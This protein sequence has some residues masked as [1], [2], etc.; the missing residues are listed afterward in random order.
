M[1]LAAEV[2]VV[3]VAAAV[4]AAWVAIPQPTTCP[5]WLIGILTNR[6]LAVTVVVAVEV[7]AMAMGLTYHPQDPLLVQVTSHREVDRVAVVEVIITI[8]NPSLLTLKA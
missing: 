8:G 6:P 7:V 5:R 1:P 4:V 3:A 2:T